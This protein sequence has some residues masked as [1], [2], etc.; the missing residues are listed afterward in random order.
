MRDAKVNWQLVA[1]GNTVN[2]FTDPAAGN[3]NSKGAAYNEK[4]DK[5]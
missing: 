4:A 5:L 1:Y 3:D 2:S